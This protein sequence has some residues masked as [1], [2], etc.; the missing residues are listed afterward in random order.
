MRKREWEKVT[1]TGIELRISDWESSALT[2]EPRLPDKSQ[3]PTPSHIL[4]G[5]VYLHLTDLPHVHI[6][7]MSFRKDYIF[8]SDVNECSTNNGGCQHTC[9]NTLGSFR[10]TCRSG[11][12]LHSN[13]RNCIGELRVYSVMYEITSLIYCFP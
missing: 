3:P 9:T 8:H 6:L 4:P 2:T 10:C 1:L 11:Y 5:G 7:Y 12:R 13:G